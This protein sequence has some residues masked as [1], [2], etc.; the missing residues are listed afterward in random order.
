MIPDKLRI[1]HILDSAAQLSE[2]VSHPKDETLAVRAN[3]DS[4]CYNFILIGEAVAAISDGFKTAHPAVP[5]AVMKQMRNI[6]V[7]EYM[8]TNMDIVWDTAVKDVPPLVAVLK[9][10]QKE[11]DEQAADATATENIESTTGRLE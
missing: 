3:R 10:L 2:I 11:L 7:H 5:W 8:Q 6:L 4:L 1:A 9:E